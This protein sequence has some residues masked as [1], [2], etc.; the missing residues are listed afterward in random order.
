MCL[1]MCETCSV[2]GGVLFAVWPLTVSHASPDIV[3]AGARVALRTHYM[4]VGM[5]PCLVSRHASLGA[6]GSGIC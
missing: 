5:L 6:Q 1:R 2:H 4:H 3:L